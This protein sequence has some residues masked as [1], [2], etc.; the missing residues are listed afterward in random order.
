MLAAQTKAEND[1][2]I[3]EIKK[4]AEVIQKQS[5]EV[6]AEN[7]RLKKA[8]QEL[9][10][11]SEEYKTQQELIE[12]QNAVT[13][14]MVMSGSV[15]KKTEEQ[16]RRQAEKDKLIQEKRRKAK[17][18]RKARAQQR[19]DARQDLLDRQAKYDAFVEDMVQKLA[20][21]L[22]EYNAK[23]NSGMK[24]D[25]KY[26]KNIHRIAKNARLDFLS[27]MIR[28]GI[29][30]AEMDERKLPGQFQFAWE[31]MILKNGVLKEETDKDY[32]E[33]CTK[34]KHYQSPEQLKGVDTHPTKVMT[35]EGYSPWRLTTR[36]SD[37]IDS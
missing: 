3:Q 25:G 8:V 30:L 22:A 1:R 37:G 33:A 23:I 32:E 35:W 4:K 28:G 10:A 20:E 5:D 11:Q 36:R 14:R 29:S 19:R 24:G 26:S 31:A 6:K 9:E 34:S 16:R 7:E 2:I 27:N 13:V 18:I 12:S 21:E 15:D 17:E